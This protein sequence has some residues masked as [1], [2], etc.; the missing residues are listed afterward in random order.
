MENIEFEIESSES[1]YSKLQIGS[2][3]QIKELGFVTN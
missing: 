3:M 2:S 1:C